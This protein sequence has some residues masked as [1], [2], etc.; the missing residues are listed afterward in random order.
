MNRQQR[1]DYVKRMNTP[2]KIQQYSKELDFRIRYFI[3]RES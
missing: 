2:E 1:R 3:N